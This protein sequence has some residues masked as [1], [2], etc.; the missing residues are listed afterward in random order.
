MEHPELD[1]LLRT[2][3]DKPQSAL[4]PAFGQDVWRK[5]RQEKANNTTEEPNFLG[6][7]FRPQL[8]AASLALALVLGAGMGMGSR[9][10]QT[11]G[12]RTQAAL[13]LDVFGGSAPSL[14]S[15]LLSD[16]L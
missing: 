11:D 10:V 15:T 14:P 2:Y 12:P 13:N 16:R 5:I 8:V 7:L 4:P 9:A 1:E 3:G 6:W